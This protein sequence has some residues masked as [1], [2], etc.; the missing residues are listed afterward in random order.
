MTIL[1]H[2]LACD[3]ERTALLKEADDIP[4]IDNLEIF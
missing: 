3:E 1:D 2:V 4:N